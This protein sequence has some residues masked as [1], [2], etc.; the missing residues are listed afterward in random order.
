MIELY[1]SPTPSTQ[2]IAIMLEE[3]GLNYSVFPIKKNNSEQL[4]LEFLKQT[5]NN[6]F[7]VILDREGPD[8]KPLVIFEPSAILLYLAEKSGQLMPV[9]SFE[10]FDVLQWLLF[11]N[12]KIGPTLGNTKHFM[13]HAPEEVPYAVKR[14]NNE[15][16]RIFSIIE[17]QLAENDYI[18][19]EYS[20]ADIA[21]YPWIKEYERYGLTDEQVPSI[22]AWLEKLNGRDAIHRGFEALVNLKD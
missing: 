18:A 19:G 1:G 7:P 15:A 3:V 4:E 17:N 22:C 16:K 14:F 2:T 9:K 5:P 6:I 10:K 21:T 11:E 20:I 8:N 13:Y 12:S